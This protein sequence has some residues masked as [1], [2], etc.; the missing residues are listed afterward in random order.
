M[1]DA[2]AFGATYVPL[3]AEVDVRDCTIEGNIPENLSG[4]FYAVGP[5][6]QYPLTPAL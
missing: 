2:P 1:A 5:D 4:G 6:P 3:H